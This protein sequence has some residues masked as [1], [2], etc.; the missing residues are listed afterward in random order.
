MVRWGEEYNKLHPNVKIDVSAGGAGKGMTD[1]LGGLADIGMVS[2]EI[3]PSE[4]QKGAFAIKVVKDAVV[5]TM[6]KNNPA[7]ADVLIQGLT[8]KQFK[9]IFVSGNLT[10]W[11]AAVSKPSI[12]NK[13]TVYVRSDSCGAADVWGAYLGVKQDGLKGVGVSGDPGI[14]EAVSS[15]VNGIGFN[16]INFAFDSNTSLPLGNLAIIPLDKNGNGKIDADENF[17]SNKEDVLA[18]IA[19][20]RYPSP[21][22][23]ELY[24]VTKDK[25]SGETKEFAKWILT[26]GQKYVVEVGYVPLPQDVIQAQ[27]AKIDA[28]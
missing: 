8:Q 23:R 27:L 2:R 18:A 14:A 25:F 22:S 28:A 16:N 21:P 11:G 15:D 12:T 7:A 1:A 26:D 10:L 19:D 9:D 24:L 17:Y 13:I 3:D 5:P 4:V 20:G 6:N